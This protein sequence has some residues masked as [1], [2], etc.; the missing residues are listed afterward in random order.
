MVFRKVKTVFTRLSRERPL[1]LAAMVFVAGIV[2][3]GGFN[4][5]MEATNTLTFCVSCHE[6]GSTVYPEYKRSIHYSNPSGVQ[7]ACPDC[8]VPK[9]W[10]HKFV[11]KVQASK[12]LFYWITGEI[13]TKEKFEAKRLQLAR[14]VWHTMESTDSRECR[15]CHLLSVMD[16]NGQARFAARIHSDA[17]DKKQTCID[18]HKGI[19]H[20]LPV[21]EAV[22]VETEPELDT[23]YAME[24]MDT[25]AGCHGENGEGTSDGEYPRL[26]GLDA[27][28]LAAQLRKFKSRERVNIPMLPYATERELPEEDVVQIATYLSQI[29]LPTRLPPIDQKA[30][31]AYARLQQS[32]RVLNIAKYPGNVDA[33]QRFYHKECAGCHGK[34]A[35]GDSA[36]NIPQLAG[37]HSDYLMRQ[38][39]RFRKGERLH[40]D[41]RDADI[42]SSFSDAEI[43]DL[44]AWLSVLDDA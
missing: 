11:R 44:L 31:N 19:A 12:E 2:F 34:S 36:R 32:K 25:C 30:F 20:T 39:N 42:F 38:I 43:G 29:D 5:A 26:A 22:S 9:Q 1:L 23:E 41:P 28:Y 16:L 15:N 3:W 35:W 27:K 8:H 21:E 7:A 17:I 33:G 13:D 37:Q 24:I 10:V 4:T 6:M 18:C 14:R 40:D